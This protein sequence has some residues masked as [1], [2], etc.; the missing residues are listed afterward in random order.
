MP[1]CG[2]FASPVGWGAGALLGAA[3]GTQQQHD[4]RGAEGGEADR[5]VGEGADD[6]LDLGTDLADEAHE[7]GD[8]IAGES[9]RVVDGHPEAFGAAALQESGE[10][11]GGNRGQPRVPSGSSRRWSTRMRT[12]ASLAAEMAGTAV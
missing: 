8:L 3:Q 5:V 2:L 6:G 11:A 7:F 1:W 12:G 4:G 9:A 10:R